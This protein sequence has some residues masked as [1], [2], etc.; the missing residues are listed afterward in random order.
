MAKKDTKP[1]DKTKVTKLT[2]L[3]VADR[4]FASDGEVVIKVTK[5]GRPEYIAVPITSDRYKEAIQRHGRNAPKP[6]KRMLTPEECKE[7]GVP[8][9]SFAVDLAD[10]K[11]LEAQAAH[12][13]RFVTLVA[14]EIIAIP[15]TD[16]NGRELKSAEERAEALDKIGIS[17]P[18]LNAITEAGRMLSTM[19]EEE[20]RLFR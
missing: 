4:V 19:T 9:G 8:R 10:E 18:H 11:Y 2:A 3:N 13:Q 6:P 20:E 14:A 5:G 1:A 15:I 7:A 16:E 12:D 17:F